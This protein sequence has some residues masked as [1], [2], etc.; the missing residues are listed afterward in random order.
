MILQTFDNRSD[1]L[2][3][4]DYD[5]W[6]NQPDAI[7]WEDAPSKRVILQALKR[8]C[9]EFQPL[10]ILDIASGTGTF[11]EKIRRQ[12]GEIWQLYGI[13]FSPVA[14]DLA[15]KRSD[16]SSLDLQILC[17]DAMSSHFESGFFDIV[18]CCGSW[19]HFEEPQK[20][21]QETARILK[22]GGWFF[23]MIPVL[24]IDRTDREDEGWYE[25]KPIPGYA[26]R[27]KQWNLKRDTWETLFRQ[28]GLQVFADSFAKECGAIK[29]GV[30]FFGVR[31]NQ[32]FS[33]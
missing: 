33:S 17:E 29:P 16:Q 15:R 11:L 19:E 1:K 3:P 23:G 28:A 6:Y 7:H 21:L 18:T 8:C 20:M 32:A 12:I 27:Q 25:E 4:G 14:S 30:F 24:G 22:V 2:S 31:L 13:D 5:T 26:L 9:P 10:R